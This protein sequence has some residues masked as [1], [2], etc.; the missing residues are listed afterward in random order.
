MSAPKTVFISYRH[1]D[2][3]IA[4]SVY[5]E[6]RMN[7][8][9]VFIDYQDVDS[10]DWL[11][12]IFKEIDARAHFLVIVT[13]W[14][15]KRCVNEGD[16][17]AQEIRRA[18]LKRRNIV[19]LRF[20]NTRWS[21]QTPYLAGVL[22]VLPKYNDLLVPDKYFDEAMERLRARYLSMAPEDVLHPELPV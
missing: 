20:G 10:G 8:F 1:K 9:D 17:L 14:A 21:K 11:R 19:P 13:P 7:G 22:S 5:Y 15:L 12:T 16:I 3:Y 6:L 4:R 2:F 18:I